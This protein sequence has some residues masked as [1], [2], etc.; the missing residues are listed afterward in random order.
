MKNNK[1][2]LDKLKEI[3]N[4]IEFIREEFDKIVWVMWQG[5]VY[6]IFTDL[7]FQDITIDERFKTSEIVND[8][9]RIIQET[10]TKYNRIFE[11]MRLMPEGHMPNYVTCICSM[12]RCFESMLLNSYHE[13]DG[14]ID[15]EINKI[16]E[17]KL[18]QNRFNFLN[19]Y[20]Y[21]NLSFEH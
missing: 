14:N 8:L 12:L 13:I 6:Q 15:T 16:I 4:K 9:W 20:L 19:N 2:D 1:K 11:G 18:D 10:R 5:L 7:F 17:L 3:T 21:D